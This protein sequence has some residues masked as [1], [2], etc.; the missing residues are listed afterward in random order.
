[1]STLSGNYREVRLAKRSAGMPQQDNFEIAECPLR[2]CER[3]DVLVRNR[4]FRVSIST[5]LMMSEQAEAVKGIPFPPLKVGD[6][7]ADAAIGEVVTAPGASHLR[8]GD[9]VLHHLGWR[10]FAY[11]PADHCTVIR[12]DRIDPAAYL[13]HGWTA[14]AALTRCTQVRKGD[15]VFVSSGA[16][17]IGSMAGQIARRLGAGKVIGSTST[18]EKARW[19]K[20]A[21]GYDEVVIRGDEPIAEQ[22]ARFAPDG[23]DLVVD[24]V[25]GEQ[26]EAAVEV[27]REGARIVLLGAL[28]AE[29]CAG[30]ATKI[31]PVSL[32]SFN[33]IVKK[34]T[35]RGYN[36]DSDSD[37]F[38]EWID[39]LRQWRDDEALVLPRST[40]S[41]IESATAALREACMGNL[42]GV[43]LVEI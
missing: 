13:G 38:P 32:D 17:S 30:K 2:A 31:A 27:A 8:P 25:G 14:Y 12:E 19:M 9:L 28:S 42:K 41:G 5:R 3:D 40:F 37:V 11:V 34:I 43:V 22:L 23:L 10:E 29:L 21:L 36:A 33:L 15:I 16:G 20:D 26:L 6:K 18:D 39:R 35:L 4:W 1:M 7:L 24:I